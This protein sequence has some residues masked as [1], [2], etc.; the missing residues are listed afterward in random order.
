MRTF[1]GNKYTVKS[2]MAQLTL[3]GSDT[4]GDHYTKEKQRRICLDVFP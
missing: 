3:W 4:E 1:M 2:Q